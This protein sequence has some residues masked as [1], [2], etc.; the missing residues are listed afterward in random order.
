MKEVIPAWVY[1]SS[2]S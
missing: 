2:P 1:R